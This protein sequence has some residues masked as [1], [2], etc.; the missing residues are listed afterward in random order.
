MN[1]IYLLVALLSFASFC[2]ISCS[3][4]ENSSKEVQENDYGKLLISNEKFACYELPATK[5]EAS[6]ELIKVHELSA[7][8][9]YF[10]KNTD[11]N[12][13]EYAYKSEVYEN[14]KFLFIMYTN[15]EET[16]SGYIFKYNQPEINEG[17]SF[18]PKYIT[19][20]LGQDTIDCMSDLYTN[21][22]WL[23]VWYTIQ[24]AFIPETVAVVAVVC[25]IHNV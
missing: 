19:K 5:G 20:D 13:K 6:K 3:N 2:M 4:E 10:S 23:S 11:G 8:K 17:V 22:G 16:D 15:I 1:R 12:N 18:L 21:R 25:A 24:S 7:V 9:I 14:D